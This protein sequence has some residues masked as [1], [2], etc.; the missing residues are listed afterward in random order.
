M[1]QVIKIGDKEV[2]LSNNVAWLMEYREQ[3]NKDAAQELIPLMSTV[4]EMLGSGLGAYRDGEL[5]L[6]EVADSIE[7]RSFE[8]L[9][10]LY[11]AELSM[12][13]INITWAMAK[14]ADENIDPPK[15]WVRQFDTFPFDEVIPTIW[16]MNLK[17]F[18]SAK[19][20]QRLK[21]LIESAKEA[22]AEMKEKKD[23]QPSHSTQSSLPPQSED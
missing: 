9:M 14:A 4:V 12:L 17:G 15:K 23:L 11:N 6:A 21:S 19:N 8:L 10:P 13:A 1:E 22:L 7:G 3:F 18:A 16:D 20:L 5:D 2:T